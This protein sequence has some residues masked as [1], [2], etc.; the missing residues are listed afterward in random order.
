[1]ILH[2]DVEENPK[3]AL[4]SLTPQFSNKMEEFDS[5]DELINQTILK[6]NNLMKTVLEH[7]KFLKGSLNFIE[8]LLIE[9]M[10]EV[11]DDKTVPYYVGCSR[12]AHESLVLM[13]S[14]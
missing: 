11:D 3:T 13:Y 12:Q 9:E 7:P 6:C 1:M 2:F 4:F 5:I 14:I 10:K 8:K